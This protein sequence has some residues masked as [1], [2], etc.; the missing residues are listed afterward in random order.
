M[1]AR[2]TPVQSIEPRRILAPTQDLN[3]GPPGPRSRV[4]T[5]TTT[6]YAA[7]WH[8]VSDLCKIC[9]RLP[10]GVIFITKCDVTR[11]YDITEWRGI[12]RVGN[13]TKHNA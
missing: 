2:V 8:D 9:R 1:I 4:V 3:Q 6:A 12:T 5:N 13:L 11:F 10:D 7:G